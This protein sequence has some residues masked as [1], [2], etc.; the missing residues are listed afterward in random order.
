MNVF[1]RYYRILTAVLALTCALHAADYIVV[2]NKDDGP[3]TLSRSEL[4]RMYT[5]RQTN[6]ASLR[7]VPIN[8]PLDSDIAKA[9]LIDVVGMTPEEYKRY[10]VEQQV[11]G[12]A[13]APMIQRTAEGVVSIVSELPGGMGYVPAGTDVSAVKPVSVKD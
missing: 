5:G 6:L 8:L 3:S 11:R 10:W 7:V 2:A 13:T 4:K 1:A 12:Q 9:F